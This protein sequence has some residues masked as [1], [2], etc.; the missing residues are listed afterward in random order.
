MNQP[1]L[2]LFFVLV[3]G[4]IVLPGMDMAFVLA[5]ALAGGRKAGLAAVG[6]IVTGGW[7]HMALGAMGIGLLLQAAPGMFQALLV[8]GCAYV[9]W[10][11]WSLLHGAAA[12]GEPTNESSRT[13]R[14]TFGR[15]VATCLLNPKAYLFML[16]IFP[17]F[18]KPGGWPSWAQTLVLGTILLASAGLLYGLMVAGSAAL[19]GRN[20]VRPGA[21][22]WV[23]R[24]TGIYL[25]GLGVVMAAVSFLHA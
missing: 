11:G 7:V 1:D 6:G 9:A 13:T 12:L 3:F 15:A 4:I 21:T 17:H 19:V 2:W 8:A 10:I 16:A 14:A 22:L 20:G 5:S 25:A 24:V 18:L 23:G